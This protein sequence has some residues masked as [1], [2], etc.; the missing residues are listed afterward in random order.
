MT[1]GTANCTARHCQRAFN[2]ACAS[3][4]GVVRMSRRGVWGFHKASAGIAKA[5]R[6]A[7]A[8]V[9]E[10]VRRYDACQTVADVRAVLDWT[11]TRGDWFFRTAE[12]D[13]RMREAF[14]RARARVS[15]QIRHF[16]RPGGE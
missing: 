9:D 7:A 5:T 6:N 10:A 11:G 13:K 16:C 15:P 4:E 8:D 3:A 12:D 14:E 1:I 2:S